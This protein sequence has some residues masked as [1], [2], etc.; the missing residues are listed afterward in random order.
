MIDTY[1][2]GYDGSPESRAAVE[3]AARLGHSAGAHVTAVNVYPFATAAYWTPVEAARY[4]ALREDNRRAAEAVLAE[5]DVEGVETRVVE[6]NSPAGGLHD[7]AE[8]LGAKLLVVGV[9]RRGP[10]GRFAPGSVAVHLL[11][12]APCPVLVTPAGAEHAPLG[13]IGVA[14]D[15]REESRAALHA[16]RELAARLRARLMIV[17]ARKPVQVPVT[18]IGPGTFD[19]VEEDRRQHHAML[20]GAAASVEG[21]YRIVDGDPGRAIAE[22]TADLDLLVTGSRGY[23]AIGSVL[24][25]SVSR[26]LVDHAHCPVLVVPRPR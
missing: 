10:V 18:P 7:L 8:E 17:G 5:L 3:L 25:G 26:H 22:M 15:S 13:L 23:G 14:Y 1:I 21:E 24:L 4:D 9:T 12:G 16:A 2:A 11:H 19:L 6:D 20:E